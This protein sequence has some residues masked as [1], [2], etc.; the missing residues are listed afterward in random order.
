LYSI[1]VGGGNSTFIGCQPPLNLIEEEKR[2][3]NLVCRK[4]TRRRK[5]M[6]RLDFPKLKGESCLCS[7]VKSE[8]CGGFDT[9]GKLDELLLR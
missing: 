6:P 7:S 4:T 5:T 3:K 9:M 8:S 2:P 1:L